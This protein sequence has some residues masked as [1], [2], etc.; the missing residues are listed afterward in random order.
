[1]ATQLGDTLTTREAVRRATL[2][3]LVTR[4]EIVAVPIEG[5]PMDGVLVVSMGTLR[6]LQIE[7]LRVDL[8]PAS[9]KYAEV[10]TPAT[11]AVDAI[12]PECLEVVD[13][14]V[15]LFPRLVVEGNTTEISVKAKSKPVIHMHGQQRL[16]EAPAGQITVE[17][18]IEDLRAKVLGAVFDLNLEH[19][20]QIDPGPL[21]S[22]DLVAQ[23]LE[24][25]TDNDRG[26][27]EESLYRWAQDGPDVPLV[28]INHA[29][30]EPVTYDL[31][32]AGV[33]LV[34]AAREPI[35]ED[36]DDDQDGAS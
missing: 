27:L 9:D 25:A 28:V 29:V 32:L 20:A 2:V 18:T 4:A 24:V 3:D 34:N 31:T 36:D 13:V 21:V 11:I 26:D 17:G 12:C 10:T 35:D 30:D 15:K 8:P 6:A 16:P 19:E 7:A 1:M 33:A 14:P 5:G 23:R 22:L